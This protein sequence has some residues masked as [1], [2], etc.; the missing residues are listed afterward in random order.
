M[1]KPQCGPWRRLEFK[2]KTV[3]DRNTCRPIRLGIA[4]AFCFLA[5]P[6]YSS[7]RA[8]AQSQPPKTRRSQRVH[9]EEVQVAS[10]DG[11]LKF[12]VLPNSERSLPHFYCRIWKH[13]CD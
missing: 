6:S 2:A 8:H 13:Y 9:M 1:R 7:A 12:T 3:R 11:K 4:A 10:P 5:Q